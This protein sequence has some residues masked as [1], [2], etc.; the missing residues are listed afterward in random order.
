[1]YGVELEKSEKCTLDQWC[2]FFGI[3]VILSALA[4]YWYITLPVILL[5]SL[6]YFLYLQCCKRKTKTKIAAI[7][8][9]LLIK[10]NC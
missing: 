7:E 2:K 8:Q 10:S 4:D 5:L 6:V 9:P 3:V 1:M